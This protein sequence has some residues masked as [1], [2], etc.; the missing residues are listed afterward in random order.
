MPEADTIALQ[1]PFYLRDSAEM[2]AVVQEVNLG[3]PLDSIFP[4]VEQPEPQLHKSL[5]TH[6]GLP[7]RHDQMTQR[8]DAAVPAWMFVLLLVLTALVFLYYKVRKI[9]FLDL[10]KS[11]LDRRVMDR[12]VRDCNLMRS[13][14][15]VPV[16]LLLAAT[17]GLAIYVSAMS[18]MGLLYYLM[19]VVV[20]AV[21][22][23]LRNGVLRL[24]ANVF[25]N[26]D[27]VAAYIT[28]NYL[29]HLV[30]T[31]ALVPLLLLLVYMPWG[32]E[33]VQYVLFGM[34]ALLFAVR[35][36][37]GVNLFFTL[38]KSFNFY[39]FYY[40]CTVEFVPILVLLKLIIE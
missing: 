40:L 20:L 30:L 10:L 24:I 3:I 23:L 1:L 13:S 16:G 29:F 14:Q 37:R 17:M 35:M 2:P 27:A 25:D 4:V 11:T 8:A 28:S 31:T 19:T 5:F 39:L 26:R 15:L 21:A 9:K 36:S 6:H 38:S 33:A 18:H 22:Y 34:V 7:V 12:L 32:T